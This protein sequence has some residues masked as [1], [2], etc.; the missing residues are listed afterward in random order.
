MGEI[1]YEWNEQAEVGKYLSQG[2]ERAE[3]GGDVRAMI[4]GYLLAGR[5]KLTEGDKVAAGEYLA[6]AR[7]LVENASF[8][9]WTSRFERLQLEFWLAHDQLRA[10]VNWA[11]ER[12]RSDALEKHAEREEAQ[13]AVARVLILK[14]EPPSL[15]RA[16]ALL[17]PL[18]MAAEAEGRGDIM[19]KG[20]A[21]QA[22]AHWR[23]GEQGIAMT[24]LER[25][26]RLA[27]PEGYLRLFVD[28]G[29]PMGRLL[30][31]A[32]SR[33]VMPDYV[34]TI[35]AAFGG[36][37]VSS[38]TTHEALPEPLTSREHEVLKLIAAGLTNR[39]IAEQLVISP[40]TAKKHVANI[41]AKLAVSNR[42]EAAA[43][44]RQLGLL[45]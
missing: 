44:A 16:L 41:C 13:L 24:S 10:A 11:E 6:R 28:L 17:R 37:L 45:E 7:P 35:L 19:I 9:D 1:L 25:A 38:I 33:E 26:L 43:R 34:S 40:E 18:I 30:Q 22:L 32:K 23:R 29:L 27:E 39:E 14:G 12:L 42:T 15:E 20:L 21:M 36:D 31:E 4:S 2:L 3:L 8:S 5:L